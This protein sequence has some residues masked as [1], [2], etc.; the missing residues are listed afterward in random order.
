M[1]GFGYKLI[2][3]QYACGH[4]GIQDTTTPILDWWKHEQI[5]DAPLHAVM[6]LGYGTGMM[7]TRAQCPGGS[8]WSIGGAMRA[9]AVVHHDRPLRWAFVGTVKGGRDEAFNA[10]T[11]LEPNVVALASKTGVAFLYV[12]HDRNNSRCA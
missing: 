5:S 8:G 3:R 1:R 12:D 2:L 4:I 11:S 10:F 7:R 6:P 9:L